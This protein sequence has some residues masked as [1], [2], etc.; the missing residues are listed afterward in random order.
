MIWVITAFTV[1]SSYV[2]L[3]LPLSCLLILFLYNVVQSAGFSSY[4]LRFSLF[5][6]SSFF[7]SLCSPIFSFS[8]Y[9]LQYSRLYLLIKHHFPLI[10]IP[11]IF[12]SHLVSF[13]I[14]YLPIFFFFPM[15]FSANF[16]PPPLPLPRCRHS[17]HLVF[18]LICS[19]FLIFL[20]FFIFPPFLKYPFP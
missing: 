12:F 3:S 7:P 20:I 19:I 2:S 14:Y 9:L 16:L 5:P 10:L 17:Y 8:L 4:N 18:F 11:P 1:I 13:L 6:S 15:F